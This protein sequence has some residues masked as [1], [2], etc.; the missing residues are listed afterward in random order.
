MSACRLV[1]GSG[2]DP[3][4]QSMYSGLMGVCMASDA[5]CNGVPKENKATGGGPCATA[6]TTGFCCVDAT[7]EC[8]TPE[9]WQVVPSHVQMQTGHNRRWSLPILWQ[10]RRLL[11]E[12]DGRGANNNSNNQDST[13]GDDDWRRLVPYFHSSTDLADQLCR[14]APAADAHAFTC[15]RESYGDGDGDQVGL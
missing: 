6:T 11:R 12:S 2:N 1:P 7:I 5:T 3:A 10:Q 14:H 9:F 8:F 4:L 15:R 13:C